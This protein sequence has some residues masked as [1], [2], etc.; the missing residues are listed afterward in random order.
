MEVYTIESENSPNHESKTIQSP[1]K[2]IPFAEEYRWFLDHNVLSRVPHSSKTVGE[3]L[4]LPIDLL[5]A[6]QR[7]EVVRKGSA[8]SMCT[9]FEGYSVAPNKSDY[10]DVNFGVGEALIKMLRGSL[11]GDYST[12][13]RFIKS[14]IDGTFDEKAIVLWSEIFGA[15]LA[16]CRAKLHSNAYAKAFRARTEMLVNSLPPPSIIVK[17]GE[18]IQQATPFITNHDLVGIPPEPGSDEVAV[19]STI[20]I[21][22]TP[23]TRQ[24][25]LAIAGR[26]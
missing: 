2:K 1:L 22:G 11:P 24:L 7:W 18:P 5:R 8:T 9:G 14:L 13:R 15:Y 6:H 25:M 12:Q 16:V 23:T 17:S 20:G 4:V 10:S 21:L 3:R 26:Y 19:A